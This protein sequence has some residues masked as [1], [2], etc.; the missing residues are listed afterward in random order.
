MSTRDSYNYSESRRRHHWEAPSVIPRPCG[1]NVM[2]WTLEEEA[3]LFDSHQNFVR[4]ILEKK[5]LLQV[6]VTC[7]NVTYGDLADWFHRD[8]PRLHKHDEL[9]PT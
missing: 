4:C 7:G 6:C 2:T 9:L 1:L 8:V 5:D 3:R